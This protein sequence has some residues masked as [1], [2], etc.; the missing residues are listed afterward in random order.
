MNRRAYL[1]VEDYENAAF[2]AQKN[3]EENRKNFYHVQA[4]F[5]S[6]INSGRLRE[7]RDLLVRLIEELE[8][9]DSEIAKEMSQIA[10]AEFAAKCNGDYEA[11]QIS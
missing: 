5:E 8:S 3:Y 9:F 11:A 1:S 10:R 7:H 6:L 2:I 4:Y